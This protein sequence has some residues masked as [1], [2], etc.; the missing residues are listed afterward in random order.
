MGSTSGRTARFNGLISQA[1][2]EKLQ[3]HKGDMSEAAFVDLI[4]SLYFDLFKKP[5]TH[6]VPRVRKTTKPR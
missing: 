6:R 4:L 3:H 5:E 2:K 1:N